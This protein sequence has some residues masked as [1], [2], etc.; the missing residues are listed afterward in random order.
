MINNTALMTDISSNKA[1]ALSS[2]SFYFHSEQDLFTIQH[3]S[4]FLPHQ[5]DNNATLAY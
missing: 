5:K 2:T 3:V 4:W 1:A